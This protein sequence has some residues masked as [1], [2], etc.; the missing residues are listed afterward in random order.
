MIQTR[1]LDDQTYEEIAAAAKGRIPQLCPSWTDHNAHDPGITILE[2]MA[3]YKELQQF[4]MNQ[5]TEEIQWKLLQLAGILRRDVRAAQCG[6]ELEA[7][8]VSRPAGTQLRTAEGIPFELPEQTPNRPPVLERIQVRQAAETMDVTEILKR[9]QATV[10]PFDS[11]SGVRSVLQL[12]IRDCGAGP[13]R[14]WF[15]VAPPQGVPRQPFAAADQRPREI[16]WSCGG[17]PVTVLADETH[18]L[19][20]SGYVTVW[21]ESAWP[22]ASDGL[23]WLTLTLTD[24]GCEEEV[25]LC[26]ISANRFPAIQQERW[27]ASWSFPAEPSP[28]WTVCMADALAREGT[29]AVFLRTADGWTQW[30]QWS[31]RI[32]DDGREF[33]VDTSAAAP[34]G[35][36]TVRIIVQDLAHAPILLWDAAGTPGETHRLPLDGGRPLRDRLMLWCMTLQPDGTQRPALWRCVDDLSGY[37]PRDRVFVYE[38][39]HQWVRF[40]DGLHGAMVC[41]GKGAILVADLAVTLGSGGNI[42]ADASLLLGERSVRHGEA[43]GG[44]DRETVAAARTRLLRQLEHPKTC[45]T[46]EDYTRMA[47]ATPGHRVRAA[48]AIPGYDPEDPTGVGIGPVVTVVAVPDG[49]SRCPMPDARF[50]RAVQRQLEQARPIGTQVK[51]IPPVYVPI[52]VELSLMAYTWGDQAVA[53]CRQWFARREIGETLSQPAL[54]HWLRRAVPA[55]ADVSLRTSHPGCRIT[56]QGAMPLPPQAVAWM[57]EWTIRV[58]ETDP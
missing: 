55:V 26:G 30:E 40:G 12:A 25:R 49:E 5:I 22:A 42:P 34:D 38:E 45:V 44:E 2:L 28:Q 18:A 20:V 39:A 13:L 15:S 4:H 57:K 6:V 29:A 56:K 54:L 48:K 43:S 23:V 47:C 52:S 35:E 32:T 8:A 58:V 51:V 33:Q 19:S 50:L 27:A 1:N 37:G 41:G 3:W 21:A 7:S 11:G 31:S 14:L 17:R 36:E 9:Q 46:A 16:V 53:S 24:G 10:R